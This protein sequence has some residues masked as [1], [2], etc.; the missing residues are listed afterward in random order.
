MRRR[1]RQRGTERKDSWVLHSPSC[2]QSKAYVRQRMICDRSVLEGKTYGL[3]SSPHHPKTPSACRAAIWASTSF[4]KAEQSLSTMPRAVN[5]LTTF[6]K[7]S[8][9]VPI[10][11]FFLSGGVVSI[12]GAMAIFPV[13][14]LKPFLL[15]LAPAVTGSLAAG[16]VFDWVV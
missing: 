11:T 5:W 10:M 3:T 7:Y 6:C 13:L 1:R 8:R 15:Y 2:W 14:R 12:W 16:H 9:L 4:S